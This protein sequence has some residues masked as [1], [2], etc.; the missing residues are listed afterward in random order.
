MERSI[1]TSAPTTSTAAPRAA[2]SAA[3]LP[4]CKTSVA[5]LR[6]PPCQPPPDFVS[7]EDG[8]RGALVG[9]AGRRKGADRQNACRRCHAGEAGMGRDGARHS[10]PVL[11]GWLSPLD[12][13]EAAGDDA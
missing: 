13:V 10:G 11:P 6:S 12:R 5:P 2:K 9:L 4:G 1:T 8:E 3:F 7:Y